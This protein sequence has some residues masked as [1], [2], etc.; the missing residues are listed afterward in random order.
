MRIIARQGGITEQQFQIFGAIAI[1]LFSFGLTAFVASSFFS[2]HESHAE[3]DI[4]AIIENN[5]GYTLSATN[6]SDTIQMN[7]AAAP[8]GVMGVAKDTLNIKSNAPNGYKV[9]VA[10][11]NT[12]DNSL[13]KDTTGET[14]PITGAIDATSG[15][16]TTPAVLDLNSWGFAIANGT[17]GAPA[18]TFSPSYNPAVPD[19]TTKWAEM[20]VKGEEQVLQ[21]ITTPD[22]TSGV[23]LDVYYG[24]NADVTKPSGVYKGTI[25]YTAVAMTNTGAVEI[26]SVSPNK[27]KKI[28]G[29]EEL[30]ITT[31]YTIPASSAIDASNPI[32]VTFG[33][34]ACTGTG[35][36]GAIAQAD[37]SNNSDNYLVIHCVAPANNSGKYDMNLKIP[38]YAKDIIMSN[39]LQYWVDTSVASNL[40]ESLSFNPST[41]KVSAASAYYGQA[42]CDLS[43]IANLDVYDDQ[44]DSNKTDAQNT[45]DA[46]LTYDTNAGTLTIEA[47]YHAEQTVNSQSGG[48]D[49]SHMKC[50]SA[51]NPG[52]TGN[53]APVVFNNIPYTR[54]VTYLVIDN[55]SAGN[56]EFVVGNYYNLRT[57]PNSGNVILITIDENGNVSKMGSH[58]WTLSGTTLQSGEGTRY[59]NW[60]LF[61]IEHDGQGG[62][63]SGSV[64][65]LAATGVDP[66]INTASNR[67]ASF[68]VDRTGL[69][70]CHS[71][72]HGAAY[73][74]ESYPPSVTIN[75][76]TNTVAL[77]YSYNPPYNSV[78]SYSVPVTVGDSVTWTLNPSLPTSSSIYNITTC[79]VVGV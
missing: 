8:G 65:D 75:G 69:L 11:N 43:D 63:G 28:N 2:A 50:V 73:N 14:T 9:Y 26:A 31:L 68:T 78:V 47:G 3:T 32:T 49:Y 45:T 27:T 64:E 29:G 30:T 15:T 37:L 12:E 19:K 1:G 51:Y 18:N 59:V 22:N 79:S 67:S 20:P 39:A 70:I 57:H 17:T 62:G 13:V 42:N 23:D 71:T 25:A 76:V 53:I 21:T 61:V 66:Y 52:S 72:H 60:G 35:T 5:G 16:F 4:S 36:D 54:N 24:V 40:C 38:K 7:V 55:G 44:W 77:N 56:G 58:T 46:G 74:L 41:L 34:K 10:M 33:G 6:S 48:V